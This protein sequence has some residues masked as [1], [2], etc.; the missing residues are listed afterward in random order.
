MKRIA[1]AL[2]LFCSLG[3]AQEPKHPVKTDVQPV[4]PRYQLFVNPNVRADTFMIDSWTGKVWVH[5][6]LTEIVGDPD[7]WM[8][9]E[10]IDSQDDL[11]TYYKTHVTKAEL[12][13]ATGKTN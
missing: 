5:T 13:A 10:R 3:F 9:Q 2:L 4:A 11:A 6:S 12:K 7:V 1:I 8:T